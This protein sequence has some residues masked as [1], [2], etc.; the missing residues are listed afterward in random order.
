MSKTNTSSTENKTTIGCR[1][2]KVRTELNMTQELFASCLGLKNCT[3]SMYESDLR[4]PS[5]SIVTK[6]CSKFN[7][8]KSYLL[9]GKEPIFHAEFQPIELIEILCSYY[10]LEETEQKF[11]KKYLDISKKDRKQLWK[12]LSNL[13]GSAKQHFFF[14]R[15]FLLA[16]QLHYC[17]FIMSITN[18]YI[19]K[20]DQKS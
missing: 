20:K 14:L 19:P 18:Y 5:S 17:F 15:F 9:Q 3:I 2:K 8:N 7:V 11:L 12:I 4:K 16:L 13:F 10:E 1:I 6:I